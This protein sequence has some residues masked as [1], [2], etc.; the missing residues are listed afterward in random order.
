MFEGDRPFKAQQMVK[1][2]VIHYKVKLLEMWNTQT[3]ESLPPLE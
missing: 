2:F 3:F 1:E